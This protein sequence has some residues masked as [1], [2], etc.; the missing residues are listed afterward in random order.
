MFF[1][2]LL[3]FVTV[4]KTSE[5]IISGNLWLSNKEKAVEKGE[6]ISK[7]LTEDR[8]HSFRGQR[9]KSVARLVGYMFCQYRNK[10]KH[11]LK[12][13]LSLIRPKKEFLDLRLALMNV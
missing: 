12:L 9:S 2:L 13:A 7:A 6:A 10:P 4:I 8:A 1:L 11:S 3:Q 5:N